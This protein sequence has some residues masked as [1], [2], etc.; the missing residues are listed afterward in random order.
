MVRHVSIQTPGQGLHLVTAE[1]EAI[2]REAGIGEGLCTVIVQHTSASLTIQE[3]ADPS[4]RR[5][6][7]R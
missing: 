5:D 1:V 4:A 2:V 7:E 6:L 3:N